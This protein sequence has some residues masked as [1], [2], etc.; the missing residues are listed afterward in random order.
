MESYGKKQVSELVWPVGRSFRDKRQKHQHRRLNSY[1]GDY[2][3]LPASVEHVDVHE[4]VEVGNQGGSLVSG[5]FIGAL[6]ALR[7]P[8]CPVDAPF[9]QAQ[10]ERMR[11]VTC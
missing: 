9:V 10:A 6:D 3:W 4:V 1:L 8:V 11:Q 7:L 5:Q 2:T